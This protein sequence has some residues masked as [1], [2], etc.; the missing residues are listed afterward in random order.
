MFVLLLLVWIVLNGSLNLQVIA[1]GVVISAVLSWASYRLLQLPP[2]GGAGR[3][4]RFSR[5]VFYILYL[6]WEI[7]RA[8]LQVMGR[9][10]FP[11]R[12]KGAP[13]LTW[14]QSG[15]KE[16]G[17][18]DAAGQLHHSDPGDHHGLPEKRAAVRLRHGSGICRGAV[19]VRLRPK[20]AP[21]GGEVRWRNVR[22]S[23][24]TC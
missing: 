2:M 13:K 10:L 4:D 9:I 11:K 7:L 6:A 20:T 14:F 1:A 3:I 8:N 16:P 19:G 5:A 17:Q 15:L 22:R 12:R 21:L 23:C 24:G 18:P